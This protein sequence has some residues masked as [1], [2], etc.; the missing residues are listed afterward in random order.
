MIRKKSKNSNNNKE[1]GKGKM[2]ILEA[3]K[4]RIK[5]SQEFIT[6]KRERE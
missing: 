5:K 4:H 6:G 2:E 3:Y 1:G